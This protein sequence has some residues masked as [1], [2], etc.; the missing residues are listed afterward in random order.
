MYSVAAVVQTW[1]LVLHAKNSILDW[2]FFPFDNWYY[3]WSFWWVKYALVE[4]HTNPF[5]TDLL[6]F[7]Q[8]AD[9]HLQ[10]PIVSGVLSI[11]LQLATG[12]LI[13]SSNVLHLLFLVL[14]ALGTYALAYRVT[15]N[16]LASVLAGYIFAFA[17][18][19]LM[20]IAG[21]WNISATWPIPLFILF[22]LRF[23]ESGRL[24]E[25]A[26]AGILWALLTLNWVEYGVDAGLFA[27]LFLAY[28]A[29]VYLRNKDSARFVTLL[30]GAVVIGAVWFIIS[31][32]LLLPSL[33]SIYGDDVVLPG[34]DD[35]FS[36]DLLTFVTPSPFW[37]PGLYPLLGGPNPNHVP[38]GGI[39][40]TAYLGFVPLLL[41]GLSILAV[42]RTPHR[43]LIWVVAFFLFGILSLGPYLYVGDTKDLSLLGVSFTI[44]LPYQLYD[45]L[46]LFGERRVPA[47]MIVFG[48]MALSIL[49][50]IGLDF[51]TTWMKPRYKKIAPLVAL[52]VL[53]LVVLEYW[54]PPVF[55]TELSTPAVF[56]EIRDEEGDFTVL[57]APLGRRNGFSFV[58]DVK[59][60]Q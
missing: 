12:N 31:A 48:I 10:L 2:F 3:L 41:A 16:H 60:G 28:W 22:L 17:P 56:D 45:R 7:P 29:F 39:E 54:N 6:L 26:A 13:L 34:G 4:L 32:P 49:A 50:A 38:L 40:N 14:S 21:H 47:R 30:R 27:G 43:V 8:G 24:K 37:G 5:H 20:H 57:H 11:P 25:A 15:R 18:F 52:L 33:F 55:L 19:F 58:G 1:P 36:A 23:R 59:G 9:L 53:S 44:P 46:P 51:L 35:V 42:R